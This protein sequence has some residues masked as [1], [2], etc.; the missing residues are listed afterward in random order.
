MAA[1]GRE[2]AERGAD[3]LPVLCVGRLLFAGEA[4]VG[5]AAAAARATALP[6]IWAE[7]PGA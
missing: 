6:G 5:E 4:R 2:L 7:H 1:A 3:R